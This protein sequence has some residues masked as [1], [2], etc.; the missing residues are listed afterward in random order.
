MKT[1]YKKNLGETTKK[2]YIRFCLR[3]QIKQKKKR[4]N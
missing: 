2:V 3:K 4:R 1:Q